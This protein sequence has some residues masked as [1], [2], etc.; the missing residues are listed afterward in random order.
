MVPTIAYVVYDGYMPDAHVA[1]D[2]GSVIQAESGSRRTLPSLQAREYLRGYAASSAYH[3][4]DG[5]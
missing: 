1:S 2:L 5:L 3:S 4:G